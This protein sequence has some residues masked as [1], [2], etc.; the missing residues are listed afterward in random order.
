MLSAGVRSSSWASPEVV[1]PT[2][3]PPQTTQP[4]FGVEALLQQGEQ[5]GQVARE[6]TRDKD[7]RQIGLI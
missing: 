6:V 1:V 3:P 4:V 5:A 2:T 7:Q